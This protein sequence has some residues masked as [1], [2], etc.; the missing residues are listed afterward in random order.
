ARPR[1]PSP[2]RLRLAA[3]ALVAL[4]P[5]HAAPAGV[6]PRRPGRLVVAR[7]A[8]DRGV[9]VGGERDGCALRPQSPAG[10]AGGADELLALLRPGSAVAGEY[11]CRPGRAEG[12]RPLAIR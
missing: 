5:P 6:D 2:A 1:C 10:L 11:P 9:A 3:S 4:L 8:H 12:G 7:P